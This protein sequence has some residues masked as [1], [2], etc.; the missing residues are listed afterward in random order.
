VRIC[1]VIRGPK[2]KSILLYYGDLQSL[3]WDSNKFQWPK[4]LPARD[5]R[6]VANHCPQGREGQAAPKAAHVPF[7]QFNAKMGRE[8]LRKNHVVANPVTRKWGG[9]LVRTHKLRWN[10]IWDLGRVS[11][12]AGLLWLIW[13]RA[14][15]V[16]EWRLRINRTLDT[17]CPVCSRG[18]H[19]T[20]LYRFWKCQSARV[21][22]R[23]GTH[24]LN[25]LVS[26][27]ESRGPW[28]P[29]TWKQGI[30]SDR[31][32]CRFDR[33]KKVWM[34]LRGIVLW[35]LWLER[36]DAVFNGTRWPKMKMLQRIWLGLVDYGRMEWESA[37]LKDDGKFEAVWC[38][39]DLFSVM[40]NK[41]PR[42]KLVG[43]L[44]GFD[45]H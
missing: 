37:Q 4:Q 22:W 31:I 2:K 36:N 34:A 30:F 41:R 1:E 29:F 20:A 13:H 38:R 27:R 26:D 39:K 9:V 15:V 17:S 35:Q 19:E 21:A 44:D 12:E 33:V 3:S 40:V 16:N 7:M 14:L 25:I 23:W 45:V 32:P 43:P 11:K 24:I 18:V 28:R 6:T 5:Q 42:W 10:S 8:L